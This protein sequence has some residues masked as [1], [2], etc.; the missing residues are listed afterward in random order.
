M[1]KKVMIKQAC[2]EFAEA[3]TGDVCF[4]AKIGA[5]VQAIRKNVIQKKVYAG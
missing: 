5:E 3:K 1:D 2:E 4:P